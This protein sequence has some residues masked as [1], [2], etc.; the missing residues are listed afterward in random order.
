MNF[1]NVIN[2]LYIIYILDSNI[3]TPA[4]FQYSARVFFICFYIVS[5]CDK[6]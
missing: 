6:C 1:V 3:R 4:Q 5:V 2:V